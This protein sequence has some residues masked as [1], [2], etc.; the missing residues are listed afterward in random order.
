MPCREQ[1]EK[2]VVVETVRISSHEDIFL[3]DPVL[4]IRELAEQMRFQGLNVKVAS[5]IDP[6]RLEHKAMRT[7]KN[8]D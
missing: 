8:Q 4:E 7:A 1:Q 3:C 5:S 6:W 2:W